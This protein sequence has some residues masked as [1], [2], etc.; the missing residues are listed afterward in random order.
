MPDVE[1]DVRSIIPDSTAVTARQALGRL[2]LTKIVDVHRVQRWRFAFDGGDA[3]ELA[4]RLERVDVLV[5]ANKHRAATRILGGTAEEHRPPQSPRPRT[6]ARAVWVAV[7][8]RHDARAASMLSVL[9]DR[10]GF[11]RLAG[12]TLT[13]LWRL[14]VAVDS[15]QE[16]REVGRAAMHALLVNP[17]FQHGYLL[18]D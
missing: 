17:Q 5:N 7:A 9:R 13:E 1:L 18:D 3:E 16:A 4:A 2:G 10:L 8:A 14:D 15:P 11:D 6:S 12:C